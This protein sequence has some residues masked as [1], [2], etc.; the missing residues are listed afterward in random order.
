MYH[1]FFIHSYVDEHI[2][3]FPYPAYCKHC[4]NEH[5]GAS[6]F[7]NYVFFLDICPG[8]GLQD[9]KVSLYIDISLSI[10]MQTVFHSVCTSLHSHQQYRRAPFISHL[11]PHLLFVDFLMTA[12]LSGASLIAQ[13]VKNLPAMQ[14]I[15]N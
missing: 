6:I 2:A 12:I 7:S 5:W 4:C 9:H 10:Y 1:I 11:L 14:E 3:Y 8:V 15:P 13:L